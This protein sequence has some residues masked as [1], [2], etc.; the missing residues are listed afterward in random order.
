MTTNGY[1]H[2]GFVKNKSTVFC[3]YINDLTPQT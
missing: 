3:K 1:L 2:V